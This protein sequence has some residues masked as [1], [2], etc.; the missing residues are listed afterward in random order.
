MFSKHPEKT[1]VIPKCILLNYYPALTKLWCQLI[2]N[3]VTQLMVKIIIGMKFRE[4]ICT[5]KS[6]KIFL[7]YNKNSSNELGLKIQNIRK[8]HLTKPPCEI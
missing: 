7:W 3:H 1:W 5:S 2:K 6:N 4:N 8:H